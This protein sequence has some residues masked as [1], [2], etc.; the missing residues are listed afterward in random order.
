MY[1]DLVQLV[2]VICDI[3]EFRCQDRKM[4]LVALDLETVLFA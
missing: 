1:G 2:S 4:E 3:S